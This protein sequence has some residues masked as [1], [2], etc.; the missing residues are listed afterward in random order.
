M[1]HESIDKIA[2]AIQRHRDLELASEATNPAIGRYM[3][4]YAGVIQQ[5]WLTNKENKGGYRK[6][7]D[8]TGRVNDTDVGNKTTITEDGQP[9]YK[10][11][12][13]GEQL[14]RNNWEPVI[15]QTP[16]GPK[17]LLVFNSS[18]YK[19]CREFLA[20]ELTIK[21]PELTQPMYYRSLFDIL[22]SIKKLEEEISTLEEKKIDASDEEI[23]NLLSEIEEK[24][25]EKK[26]QFEKAQGFIRNHAEL[27]YQPVLD[28]W[29]EEI[30]R[31]K[32]F[33]GSLAINGGPGT[34]K[35]TS[36]IQRIKFLTDKDALSEYMP[37]LS[38]GLKDKLVNQKQSWVFFSPSELLSLYLQNSMKEEGLDANMERVKVWKD[39]RNQLIQQYKLFNTET[40]RPFLLLR[41]SKHKSKT[42]L[43]VEGDKLK[44]FVDQ[45]NLFF[46]NYQKEK[47]QKLSRLSISQF[48]WKN[49]GQSILN[50]LA[51]QKGYTEAEQLIRLY[52]NLQDNFYEETKELNEEY[53]SLINR[54][55]A[56]HVLKL[57]KDENTFNEIKT[58]LTTLAQD[59]KSAQETE[60][61][62]EE[63]IESLDFEET[64][65][66]NLDF[67]AVLL[68]K[69]KTLI[70]K[71]GLIKFDSNTRFTK[72]DRLLLEH[73]KGLDQI[74]ELNRIGQLAYF[75]KYFEGIL[76]GVVRNI[77]V[78]IPTI[79][80]QFRKEVSKSDTVY[81]HP[82]VI[83]ELVEKDSNKRLH[84]NEQSFLLY[85]INNLIKSS[86][87]VSPR[88]SKEISHPYFEAFRTNSKPVIG[89]DEA[90]D[91]HLI[92]LL[93]MASLADPELSAVTYS[94]DLM[95]RLTTEGLRDW[96]DLK[97]F[98]NGFES[99]DLV[100][101][102]RQSN[103]L[104]DLAQTIYKESTNK[105]PDY[106]SYLVKDET[107][108][109]PLIIID[110]DEEAIIEWIGER[111]REIY[112]AYGNFIPS[113]AI[114]LP[115]EDGLDRFATALGEL[116]DLA[117][118]GIQV[119]A[120]RNGEVLGN[121]NTV[122]VFSIENIKGLEFEAVFF[123]NLNSLTTKSDLDLTIKNLYVGLSRATF[124]LAI[125]SQ[126]ELPAEFSY[127]SKL[128]KRGGTWE[129]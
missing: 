121:K 105:E 85:F 129:I 37:N 51:K 56:T 101:S 49:L 42:L 96:D 62:D 54:A 45:F 22:K 43:P 55:A 73:I 59:K 1:E 34:G 127:L 52:N 11:L 23:E 81:Q 8:I 4:E 87:K 69:L 123:H 60:E 124:Y 103:T 107:E 5:M 77:F 35:T 82:E 53:K 72:N 111:I 15:L 106:I 7:E 2:H 112:I 14:I 95:Q 44:K 9:V 97:L 31:S 71:S 125:T 90:T 75:K 115:S 117:D 70:R 99:K 120:C 74:E 36:L 102:Y 116:D 108:P 76:K 119:K 113:I 19:P 80:K 57:R 50:Y 65:E 88:K 66:K 32:I 100:I 64:T 48:E 41:S 92:D 78:E 6:K 94:G 128:L 39:H 86:F 104:L 40:Q 61:L 63:E 3:V 13:L 47:L 110:E 28:P 122:R 109:P 84:P 91:F 98:A 126:N 89:V 114:F 67:E 83:T 16:A 38:S 29:Q 46:F 33:E 12:R 58:L 18:V 79:Y 10:N 93:A 30:K 24:K 26:R 17:K 27:R 21:S 25:E 20:T 118:V 68:T